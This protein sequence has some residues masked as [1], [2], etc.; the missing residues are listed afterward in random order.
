MMTRLSKSTQNLTRLGMST[1]TTLVQATVTSFN[2]SLTGLLAP[3]RPSIFNLTTGMISLKYKSNYV[4]GLFKAL[5]WLRISHVVIAKA[6][7]R[8]KRP[9]L[10]WLYLPLSYYLLSLSARFTLLCATS[11]STSN[12]FLIC[13][14]YSLKFQSAALSPSVNNPLC[15]AQLFLFHASYSLLHNKIKDNGWF[16]HRL[17]VGV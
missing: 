9:C 13:L 15:L 11:P 17:L 5:L 2:S 6:L 10:L 1:A 3:T 7:P 16:S 8:P 12:I 4:T 14:H